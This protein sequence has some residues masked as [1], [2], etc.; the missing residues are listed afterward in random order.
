[1][2]RSASH[3]GLSSDRHRGPAVAIVHPAHIEAL[4][5]DGAFRLCGFSGC[6]GS[7]RTV[8]RAV[9]C[10]SSWIGVRRGTGTGRSGSSAYAVAASH[11]PQRDQST[12]AARG[13]GG[14]G[15]LRT[16][17]NPLPL[18]YVR[19]ERPAR[20]VPSVRRMRTTAPRR[21][22]RLTYARRRRGQS[23]RSLGRRAST[24]P[25]RRAAAP[26]GCTGQQAS[27]AR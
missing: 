13:T 21:K 26:G 1:M 10:R 20:S 24:A 22:R 9:L 14:R 16:N 3:V 27:A 7:G 12:V 6:E 15:E 2:H 8:Q 11:R 25:S 19:Q 23:R 4:K 5:P 17:I 18:A